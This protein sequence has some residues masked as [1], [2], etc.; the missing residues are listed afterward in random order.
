MNVQAGG[1]LTIDP[2]A[3][4]GGNPASNLG[5]LPCVGPPIPATSCATPYVS[6]RQSALNDVCV[7]STVEV[8]ATPGNGAVLTNWRI[9]NGQESYRS[10]NT[11]GVWVTSPGT[12][13]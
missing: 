2:A 10:G 5:P 11:L 8:T 7:G 3:N 1:R 9:E 13:Y 12:K 4:Q 6:L